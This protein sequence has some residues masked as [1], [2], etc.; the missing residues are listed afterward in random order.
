MGRLDS[1]FCSSG[2]GGYRDAGGEWRH[3]GAFETCQEVFHVSTGSGCTSRHGGPLPT[4][5]GERRITVDARFGRRAHSLCGVSLYFTCNN[6]LH[7]RKR[8]GSGGIVHFVLKHKSG[9]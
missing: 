5:A 1:F 7:G 8:N 9:R 3:Q 2:P 6:N 4:R